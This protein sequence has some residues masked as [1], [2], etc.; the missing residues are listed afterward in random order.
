VHFLKPSDQRESDRAQTSSSRAPIRR[1]FSRRP[2]P[3]GFGTFDGVGLHAVCSLA[4]PSCYTGYNVTLHSLDLA[5]NAL[6]PDGAA[7]LAA[8]YARRVCIPALCQLDLS[9]NRMGVEG[10]HA[11]V[12]GF[13]AG[14]PTTPGQRVCFLIANRSERGWRGGEQLTPPSL[15]RPLSPSDNTGAATGRCAPFKGHALS[16][17]CRSA[18]HKFTHVQSG[19]PVTR[20][21]RM[22]R[23]AH[24]I[25]Q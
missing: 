24:A 9:H 18:T 5:S 7:V 17:P 12:E 23:A 21:M 11:L 6:G 8:A 4:F 19:V 14:E 2:S 10:L 13:A 15:P 25:T 3:Q 22:I 20:A 16:R 1:Y